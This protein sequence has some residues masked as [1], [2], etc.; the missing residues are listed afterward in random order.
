[1]DPALQ[2]D[3]YSTQQAMMVF[4]M[5]YN[6]KYDGTNISLV[7]YAASGPAQISGTTM[8]ISLR[9]GFKWSDGTVID[10]SDFAYSINRELDPCTAAPA[11]AYF[12]SWIK[13]AG[14]F[15]TG[16]CPAHQADPNNPTSGNGLIG[17]SIIV[18]DPQTL[19]FKMEGSEIYAPWSFTTS[20]T[21]AVPKELIAQFGLKNWT[22]HLTDNGGFGGN[23]FNVTS[24]D[25]QGHL[26]L[27][28]NPNAANLP[29]GSPNLREVQVTFFKDA[30]TAFNAYKD[31]QADVEWGMPPEQCTAEQGKSEFHQVPFLDIGYIDP[32]WNSKPFD[33]KQVRQA[34][35]LALN[36]TAIIKAVDQCTAFAT[37][38]YIPQNNPG[39]NANLQGPDGQVNDLS[40]NPTMAKQLFDQYASTNCP[41]GQAANCPPISLTIGTS[42]TAANLGAALQAAWQSVLGINIHVKPQPFNTTIQQIFGPPAGRPQMYTIGYGV[43]F[44]DPWDWTSLQFGTG[45][46]QGADNLNAVSDPQAEALMTQADTDQG[47]D[48]ISLYQQ[49]EQIL[50][51]DVAWISLDQQYEIW[52]Q[53]PKVQ[54][55]TSTPSE[56]WYVDNMQSAFI[57]K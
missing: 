47:T 11:G 22:Q 7:P 36:K 16:K 56:Y 23:I 6:L 28:R 46:G 2:V 17:T 10:A 8:T 13:G 44:P 3:L 5:L 54:S 33:N 18:Q 4:P 43:D 57:S 26:T 38:H 53:S 15:S 51:N 35:D 45:P 39:Y 9:S 20:V 49:A 21:M 31:G 50:V 14:A 12:T 48:R 1:M 27:D 52:L 37:N 34:F 42:P 29:G 32:Q 30:E 55:Y 40:G 24:W 41:G 25:H 19:V